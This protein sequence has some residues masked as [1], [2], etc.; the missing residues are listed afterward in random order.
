MEDFGDLSVDCETILKWILKKQYVRTLNVLMWLGKGCSGRFLWKRQWSFRLDKKVRNFET[1]WVTQE[2]LCSKELVIF[3]V[4]L[5]S[6]NKL[7]THSFLWEAVT[8]PGQGSRQMVLWCPNGSSACWILAAENH[9]RSL[10]H[11][12][13]TVLSF[14]G[15]EQAEQMHNLSLDAMIQLLGHLYIWLKVELILKHE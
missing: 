3:M 11:R 14:W 2:G 9:R 7:R 8:E 4:P 12:T 6:N 1:C 13:I 5:I 15:T 10:A